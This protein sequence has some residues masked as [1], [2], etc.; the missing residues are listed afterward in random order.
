MDKIYTPQET[1]ILP[2][3]ICQVPY[4]SEVNYSAFAGV[5]N[6]TSASYKMYWLLAI[7]KE[8]ASNKK[9]VDC[10][11]KEI[12]FRTLI[13]RMVVKSWYPILKCKLS[14]GLCDSLAKVVNYIS[15]TYNFG[16]NYNDD[17]LFKF[18]Y[19]SEDNKLN[20]MLKDLT[21]NVPYRFLAPF[22]KGK[23]KGRKVE[24][25]IEELSRQDNECVY[26]IYQNEKNENCIRI[27]DNWFNYL[28][29]NRKII[30]GWAYYELT[31]FLQKRNPNVPGIAM[32]LEAPKER[33]LGEQRK[34]WKTIIDQKHI[35]DLYTGLDFSEN[36]YDEYGELSIDH[37]IPW[38][39]VL[40]DQMWNLIP[41]FKNI[42]SKKSDNLLHY[43]TYIDRFCEMQYEAFCF[44]VDEDRKNQLD[45][46]GQVLKVDNLK[47]FRHENREEE[48]VK[49]MKQEIGPVYGVAV[50]QG[51]GIVENLIF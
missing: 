45:E 18:I 6:D 29:Y 40:H 38:S 50:N 23:L 46:Y 8:V 10:D 9:E 2:K 3:E 41:T 13:S 7:L 32:K 1:I 30:E 44:V 17:K 35:K 11:K 22:F 25:Q 43:D 33:K 34:I 48:F 39:F 19:E 47:K 37:F 49:R 28:K 42:N 26:E 14:F 31:C 4:S 24:K 21:Y 15:D 51:F 20:K 36:N 16:S 5:F 12:E 27:R